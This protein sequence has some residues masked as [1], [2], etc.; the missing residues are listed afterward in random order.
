MEDERWQ[1][2]KREGRTKKLIYNVSLIV[3]I[4]LI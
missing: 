2:G 3:V 4:V 1:E